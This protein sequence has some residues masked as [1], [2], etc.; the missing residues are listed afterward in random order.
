M[1][2]ASKLTLSDGEMQLVVN[3][4]WILTKRKIID[5]VQMFFGDLSIAMKEAIAV[6]SLPKITK[7]E[8]YQQLPYVLLDYPRCF[9]KE[10]VFAV[11]TMFWWGNFFSCTLHLSGSYKTMF[12]QA[13]EKNIMQ[14]QQNNFF[15][16]VSSNEWEHHFESGNYIEANSLTETEIKAILSQRHFIKVAAKFSLYQWNEMD[17]VLQKAFSNAVRLLQY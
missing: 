11:R 10:N 17:V 9:E 6:A 3:T 4:D 2:G 7:G 16:C 8:N 15:I 5:T 12:Q 13:L 1:T 14:L